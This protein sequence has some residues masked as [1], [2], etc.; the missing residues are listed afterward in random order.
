MN[1][2]EKNTRIEERHFL[3]VNPEQEEFLNRAGLVKAKLWEQAYKRQNPQAG[4]DKHDSS[5][6]LEF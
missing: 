4:S 5:Q 3:L 1:E 2:S 6:Q